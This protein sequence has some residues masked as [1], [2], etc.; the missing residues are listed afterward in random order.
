V[1]QLL[2]D[3]VRFVDGTEEAIDVI[4]HA[5]GF[6]LSFPFIDQRHLNWQGN[7]PELY[8]NVFHPLRD[9]L[10][11]AGLIQPDSGQWGLVDYQAQLIAA[12]LVALDRGTDAGK[13]LRRRI[14]Q[15]HTPLSGGIRYLDSSRH[16]VEV[17]HFSYR[18][19]L[20]KLLAELK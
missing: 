16:L 7:R 3:R 12:Y 6:R 19:R 10:F 4:I 13:K 1:S 14:Q 17:E 11:V 20:K 18:N 9:D 8:M 2:G 15:Q 5:T